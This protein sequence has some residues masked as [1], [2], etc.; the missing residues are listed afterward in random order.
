MPPSSPPF[1]VDG[2][3]LRPGDEPPDLGGGGVLWDLSHTLQEV[4]A[5]TNT[6]IVLR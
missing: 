6:T 5:A 4:D 3:R 2:K 1:V